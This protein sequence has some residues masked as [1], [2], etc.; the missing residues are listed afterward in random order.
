MPPLHVTRTEPLP[1]HLPAVFKN[2]CALTPADTP[3]LPECKHAQ[4]P[5]TAFLGRGLWPGCQ[6]CTSALFTSSSTR[7]ISGRKPQERGEQP[8]L[9]SPFQES[10]H[11]RR[12]LVRG[13]PTLWELGHGFKGAHAPTLLSAVAQRR[14]RERE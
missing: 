9:R 3:G 12:V 7:G 6:S 8:G 13:S 11:S 4:P 1:H 2:V 14:M 10:P 5:D